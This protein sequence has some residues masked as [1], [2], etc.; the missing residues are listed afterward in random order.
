[1]KRHLLPVTAL[2]A[3]LALVLFAPAIAFS[4]NPT[5]GALLTITSTDKTVNLAIYDS[6]IHTGV[7]Q[8][9]PCGPAIPTD[10]YVL[11]GGAATGCD[12]GDP[13]ETSQHTGTATL[14]NFSITTAYCITGGGEGET[15]CSSVG[16]RTGCNTAGTICANPDTGFL[17]VTNNGP[18]FTGTIS[19]TGNSPIS[20]APY[21]PN[22]AVEG[23]PGVASDSWTQGLATGASVTL[24]LGTPGGDGFNPSDSSNCGGFTQG[25]TLQLAF[26]TASTFLFGADLYVFT[27]TSVLTAPDFLTVTPIPVP[28]GPLGSATF[29]VGPTTLGFGMGQFGAETPLFVSPLIFSANHFP[30]QACIPFADFSANGNPVCPELQLDCSGADCGNIVYA[31][32]IGYNIDPFSI[33]PPGLIGGPALLGDHNDECPTSNFNIN[34]LVSFTSPDV[35]PLS[36]GGGK[37]NSC[38]AATFDPSQPVI[39]A[40][41]TI[42]TFFGFEFPVFNNPKINKIFPLEDLNWDSN[43]SSGKGIP[44]LH[45]CTAVNPDGTCATP[46]VKAPWVHLSLL[47]IASC[48]VGFMGLDPLPGFF[49]NFSFIKPGEYT[50]LWNATTK[51][52]K[53][54]SGCQVSV[55]LQFDTGTFVNP[56]TFQYP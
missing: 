9:P 30:N 32:E 35:P 26:N 55:Q 5:S 41:T 46:G 7:V 42:S 11:Q 31:S 16:P 39:P 22:S 8:V 45:L 21:C 24:A 3:V 34:T 12:P 10:A 28:A 37:G 33:P 23:G 2:A 15:S 17:T 40:N 51:A 36:K 43:N 53:G 54:L 50:F 48:P 20:G 56:A 29:P 27:P 1:M 4:Q 18:A 49:V 14:G 38:F 47:P 13:F 52:Q 44:N 19:L 25:Q 6:Q